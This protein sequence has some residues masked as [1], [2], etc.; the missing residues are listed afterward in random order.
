[1]ARN[2]PRNVRIAGRRTSMRLEK[3]YWDALTEIARR[4]GTDIDSICTAI[5]GK[6]RGWGLSSAVRIEV[7]TYFRTRLA[8]LDAFARAALGD[9]STAR[10]KRARRRDKAPEIA[11]GEPPPAPKPQPRASD[12]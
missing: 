6:L 8:Q 5:A 11:A 10:V 4:E 2:L 9:E 7:M 3:P 12:K 1:M